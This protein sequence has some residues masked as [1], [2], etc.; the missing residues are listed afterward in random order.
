MDRTFDWIILPLTHYSLKRSKKEETN[1][2]YNGDL[3]N[4]NTNSPLFLLLFSLLHLLLPQNP[5][6]HPNLQTQFPQTHHHKTFIHNLRARHSPSSP[7][8][9][10]KNRRN[11]SRPQVCSTRDRGAVVH[12]GI[13]TDLA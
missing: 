10:Q 13:I 4:N 1:P 6:T 7:L 12:Y 11:L 9:R 3:Y 2:I 8:L 5:Q